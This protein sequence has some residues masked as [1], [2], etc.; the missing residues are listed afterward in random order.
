M[1]GFADRHARRKGDAYV[2]DANR[3]AR[4]RVRKGDVVFIDPPYSSVH[5][6]RFYHVLETIARGHCSPVTGIGRYPVSAERPRSSYSLKTKSSGAITNLFETLSRKQA[7]VIV[8][9]PGTSCSNGLSEEKIKRIAKRYFHVRQKSVQSKFSTLGG[10]DRKSRTNNLRAPRLEPLT[11]S[12]QRA[13]FSAA[14]AR[15]I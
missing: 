5:Y 2:G 13:I 11:A 15:D 6:S 12:R 7:K 3:T 10:T 9:F 14:V 8:T 1:N 4:R